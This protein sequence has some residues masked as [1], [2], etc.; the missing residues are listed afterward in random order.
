ML[1]SNVELQRIKWLQATVIK[2]AFLFSVGTKL[3]RSMEIEIE[4]YLITDDKSSRR[5]LNPFVL[6]RSNSF[7]RLH[8][9]NCSIHHTSVFSH[10]IVRVLNWDFMRLLNWYFMKGNGAP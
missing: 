3:L 8:A 4:G 9:L 5:V 2:S 10:A 1:K 6:H 7:P